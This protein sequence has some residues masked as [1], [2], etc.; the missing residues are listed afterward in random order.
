MRGLHIVS[1]HTYI[2][3]FVLNTIHPHVVT[4]CPCRISKLSHL[5]ACQRPAT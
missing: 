1:V 4:Q 3:M 5:L 2:V